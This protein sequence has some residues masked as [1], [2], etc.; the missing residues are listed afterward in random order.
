[1]SIYSS[2]SSICNDPQVRVNMTIAPNALFHADCIEVLQR[3][4]AA[5]IDLVY[6]DP[7]S[8][9]QLQDWQTLSARDGEDSSYQHLQFLSRVC[10]QAY[11]VLKPTGVLFFHTQPSSAFSIRLKLAQLFEEAN[12]RGEIVCQYS[13]RAASRTTRPGTQHD[14]ILY[15]GKSNTSTDNVVHRP[16]SDDEIRAR[17]SKSDHRGPFALAELTAPV[18][19]PGLQF[20][21]HGVMPP[22]GRSW[23]FSQATL[24]QLEEDDRIYH[25]GKD[26][27]PRLKI[28]LHE[29]EG[30]EV[31]TIW[32]DVPP[33][34]SASKESTRY[35][36]QKPLG[37]LERLLLKGSHQGEVV[38]DPFCG[39]GT[40]IVAA[41][42]H[43]RR[44]IACDISREAIEIT[45]KR[46]IHEFGQVQPT[47]FSLGDTESLRDILVEPTG[48]KPVAVRIEDFGSIG[49][50]TFVL[51][52]Q[53]SIEETR[54]Y[55]FKEARSSTGA[56]DSIV[57]TSDEYAVAFLNSEGSR[58]Y[59]GIRD[60]DRTVVGVR[61]SYQ[62]RDKVRRDVSVKLSQIEPRVDPS[63]YRVEIHGVRDEHMKKVPDLCVVELV[64]PALES[65]APYYTGSGELWV[66]V[67]GNKQKLKGPA[68]TD[69]IMRKIAKGK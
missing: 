44:W 58:I 11:R 36:S 26:S 30:V 43:Q 21:W 10:Q 24:Q 6:L 49:Q 46:L 1:M 67:D 18:S 5:S 62:D 40:T 19:R 41:E 68:L 52:Q 34:S 39:S 12:F 2:V 3:I 63:Q 31:G 47:R 20:E 57:N 38:L 53:V 7:P 13:K 61:L 28:F 54:H 14:T 29:N 65:S 25:S 27:I 17:F 60:K 59:W 8:L 22:K 33:L 35:P 48:Y 50:L 16:L 66:K 37:V 9:P 56:V 23:R 55:E 4:D 69:F 51:N 42:R 64:V 32:T 45:S 15:Y